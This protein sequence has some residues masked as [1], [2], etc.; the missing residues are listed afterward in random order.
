MELRHIYV[1]VDLPYRFRSSV[2]FEEELHIYIGS[3]RQLLE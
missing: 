2:I 1:Q 3:C